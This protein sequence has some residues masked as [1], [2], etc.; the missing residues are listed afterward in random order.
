M[1]TRQELILEFMKAMAA[2]P[3]TTEVATQS[4]LTREQKEYVRDVYL[5]AALFADKYIGLD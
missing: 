5:M 2:S 3:K 1:Q 4:M